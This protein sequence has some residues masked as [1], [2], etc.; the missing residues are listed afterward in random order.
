MMKFAVMVP[1]IQFTVTFCITGWCDIIGVVAESPTSMLS[2]FIRGLSHIVD[3][4]TADSWLTPA[5]G[6]VAC[7]GYMQAPHIYNKFEAPIQ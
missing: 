1:Y 5:I 7:H 6:S 4:G 3:V 2:W